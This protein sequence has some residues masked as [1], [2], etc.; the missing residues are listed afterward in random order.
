MDR[1]IAVIGAGAVGA[2]LAQRILES[3]I[4]D[5]VL[6]DIAKNMAI[7]KA[8]DL[9]D[10]APMLGHERTIKA[11]DNYEDIRS[12]RIIVITAG[13]TRKPGMTREDLV[14]KNAAIVRE[15]SNN[16]KE[17][18]PDALVIVVTNPLDAM[19]YLT[20]KTTGFTKQRVMGMAGVLDGSR[21][22]E[23]L[24]DELK[25]PRSSVKTLI[26]GSHG[27]TMVAALSHTTVNGKRIQDVLAKDK[28]EKIVKRTCDRGAE[29]VSLFGT[30]SA[31]YSPSAAVYKMITAIL[32]DTKETMAVSAYLEG[33]YGLKDMYIGVP[34]RIG[35]NGIE[36]VVEVDL[37]TDEKSAFLKSAQ[38][39]KSS[40]ELIK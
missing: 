33:E 6:V 28:L 27:D 1:K 24:A 35:K 9:L 23:L 17:K 18:A 30:G 13:L 7:G 4:A 29:I 8:F 26:L 12:S 21:F 14:A 20:Y 25:V 37:S 3:G 32:D 31:Y 34:C 5:V 19:T 15:V 11:T 22:I 16:I 40:L 10:A 36:N 2:T 38:A 39:I